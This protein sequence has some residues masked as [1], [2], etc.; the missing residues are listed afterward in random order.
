MIRVGIVGIGFMGWIHYLAYQKV[1]GISVGAIC[2]RDPKKREGDW[3][4]IQG[5]FGPPGEQ[6]DVSEIQ[7]FESIDELLKDDSIDVVDICLPPSMHAEATLKA[8]KA[9]RHV[10]CEKPLALTENDCRKMVQTADRQQ[11]LLMVG[12]V[13]PLFP[14]YNYIRELVESQKFGK[15][16][17]GHFKRV[18][19]DP[20]W[21]KG[22]YDPEK[23]GGP[24]LDLHVHDAHLIR[25]LFGMPKEVDSV[26]RMRG[27]VVEYC[28]S[29]FRFEDQDLSVAASSGVIRQQGRGFTHGFELHLEQAT[30][31]FEFAVMGKENRMIMPVTVFTEDGISMEP[32]LGNGDPTDAFVAEVEEVVKSVNAGKATD[33]LAGDIA[34]DAILICQKQS[35]SVERGRS[36]PI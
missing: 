9:G 17:G 6:I 32:D 16:L 22:F 10:F 4:E 15:P 2:S 34:H 20:T 25:L 19:S 31:Q 36:V 3:R 8:L 5:N 1:D 30:I 23:I 13:L 24:L 7:A 26:G 27:E 35:D 18:I 14:E 29:L 21:L 28:Q 12:H 11:R 33:L